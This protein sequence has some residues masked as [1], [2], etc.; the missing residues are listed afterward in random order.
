MLLFIN[1]Q[2]LY[3]RK[4]IVYMKITKIFFTLSM[5][6][7]FSTYYKLYRVTHAL[8]ILRKKSVTNSN[9]R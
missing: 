2:L 5:K 7:P 1:T 3:C 9:S 4:Y 6:H 8:R